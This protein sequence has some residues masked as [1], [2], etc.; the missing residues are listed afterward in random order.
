MSHSGVR[1]KKGQTL[2]PKTGFKIN[3]GMYA[4]FILLEICHVLELS[5]SRTQ[6]YSETENLCIH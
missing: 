6:E 5:E 3:S 1:Y 4:S 2:V